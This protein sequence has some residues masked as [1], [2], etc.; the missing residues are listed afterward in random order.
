M[1]SNKCWKAKSKRAHFLKVQAGKKTVWNMK[2]KYF[3]RMYVFQKLKKIIRTIKIGS[4]YSP[5]ATATI[6]TK[7]AKTITSFMIMLARRFDFELM[8][9]EVFLR[10]FPMLV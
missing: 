5:S 1:N 10:R 2:K 4:I 6:A 9:R 8:S 7:A 3:L